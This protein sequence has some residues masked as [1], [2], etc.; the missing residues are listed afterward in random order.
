ML[1]TGGGIHSG[2]RFRA[3]ALKNAVGASEIRCVSAKGLIEPQRG[4]ET[5]NLSGTAG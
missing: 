5:R 3:G 2:C 4:V 1:K